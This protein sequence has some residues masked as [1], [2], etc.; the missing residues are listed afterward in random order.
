V[1]NSRF[2]SLLTAFGLVQSSFG[3]WLNIGLT[4]TPEAMFAAPSSN[5]NPHTKTNCDLSRFIIKTSK[6]QKNQFFYISAPHTTLSC[7]LWNHKK[8]RSTPFFCL[9]AY[10]TVPLCNSGVTFFFYIGILGLFVFSG[11]L[12]SVFFFVG[13]QGS[14][15][16]K[17]YFFILSLPAP[18]KARPANSAS[19]RGM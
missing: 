10:I 7:Y 6:I 13:E 14:E 4:P 17:N 16:N 5:T 9:I 11:V 15:S 8:L 3:G 18:Q 1:S 19:R 2:V 12:W